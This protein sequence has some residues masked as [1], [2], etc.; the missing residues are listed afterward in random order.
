MLTFT[1]CINKDTKEKTQKEK[2]ATQGSPG[3]NLTHDWLVPNAVGITVHI[4]LLLFTSQSFS[5]DLTDWFIFHIS[6]ALT[7]FGQSEPSQCHT[8]DL[9]FLIIHLR[10]HFTGVFTCFAVS[11]F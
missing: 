11:Y 5:A 6:V 1:D 4:S 7:V 8:I 9:I 3:T 2:K 10:T